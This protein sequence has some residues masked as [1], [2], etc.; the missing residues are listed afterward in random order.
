VVGAV[1]GWP[2]GVRVPGPWRLEAAVLRWAVAGPLL[3]VFALAVL[4]GLV[5]G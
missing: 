4:V 2:E 3:V 5:I 1:P